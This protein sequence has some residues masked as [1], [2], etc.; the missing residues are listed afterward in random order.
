MITE[1]AEIEDPQASTLLGRAEGRLSEALA[2]LAGVGAEAEAT[3]ARMDLAQAGAQ[4]AR[5][6]Q[7]LAAQGPDADIRMLVDQI[8]AAVSA[9]V[10]TAQGAVAASQRASRQTHLEAQRAADKAFHQAFA[11]VSALY[12]QFSE[13]RETEID[14]EIADR[15]RAAEVDLAAAE[16]SGDRDRIRAA[17]LALSEAWLADVEDAAERGDPA[18]RRVLPE[19]QE[20]LDEMRAAAERLHAPDHPKPAAPA[21]PAKL[22]ASAARPE[23]AWATLPP[24]EE[25]ETIVATLKSRPAVSQATETAEAILASDESSLFDQVLPDLSADQGRGL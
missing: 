11:E 25:L 5:A 20:E 1:F 19:M 10:E 22:A 14:P 8:A 12:D 17:K 21:T 6:R 15:I 18:A 13:D 23:L 2:G 3:A 16:A 24:T 9:A 4:I 7:M